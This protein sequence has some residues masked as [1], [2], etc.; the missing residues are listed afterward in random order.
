MIFGVLS[1]LALAAPNRL[2]FGEGAS[3]VLAS[4]EAEQFGHIAFDGNPRTL[5]IG[6]PRREPLPLTVVLELPA[7]T[8]L[9]TF[10]LPDF[11]E[12]GTAKGRHVSALKI[13][14]STTSPTEGFSDLV[15]LTLKE[16][17]DGPQ[18]FPV[19]KPRAVRWVRFT[20]LSTFTPATEDFRAHNFTEIEGY[21]P[22]EPR[23]DA[24]RFEGR[25]QLRRT[26][27]NDT[28]GT[29]AVELHVSGDRITGCEQRGGQHFTVEGAVED[30][31]AKLVRTSDKGVTTP[32]TAVVLSDGQL[33]G[34]TFDGPPRAFWAA[35]AAKGGDWLCPVDASSDPW[36]QTLRD[37]KELI[38]H[39]ILFDV[40]SDVLRSD[41][42]PALERL[43]TVLTG[44]P[45]LA[46]VIEGHTDS[47]ASDAHN[48]DLSSRRA[49]AVV[50]WL[51]ERG[52]AKA[53]LTPEGKGEA[54]PIADNAT[55]AGRALNRRVEI[56]PRP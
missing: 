26:G 13:E 31:L 6:I 47:D 11:D 8:T 19:P 22:Q 3:V 15:D 12:Y 56:R 45:Q 46:V 16:G 23:G 36:E 14:G 9:E 21:G 42:K 54:E 17:V 27:L 2:T 43:L 29:N 28:P 52:V 49:K 32:Y 53:R 39:G 55:S 41:A 34:V 48:L 10:V 44:L 38:L 7:L 30:G 25:W 1:G 40:D 18:T 51:V 20:A 4:P 24:K 5:G 37:G 50:S 35:P 33:S